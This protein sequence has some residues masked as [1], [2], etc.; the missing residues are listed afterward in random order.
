MIKFAVSRRLA[1][2]L[3]VLGWLS[4]GAPRVAAETLSAADYYQRLTR[5]QL[6]LGEGGDRNQLAAELAAIEAV[7]AADGSAV[8]LATPHLVERLRDPETDLATLNALLAA[9]AAAAALAGAP[10]AADDP[11]AVLAGVLARPEFDYGPQPQNWRERLWRQL[12]AWWFELLDLLFGDL[13]PA[14]GSGVLALILL[15]LLLGVLLYLWARGVRR[16]FVP[17]GRAAAA[18]PFDELLTIAEA[19]ALAR[20][21][22]EQQHYREALRYLYLA[23][24]LTLDEHDLLRFDR[25]KTNREYLR[26]L[27]P[28]ARRAALEPVLQR[29]VDGFDR[30]WYGFEPIDADGYA[31]Y[32]QTIDQ[33]LTLPAEGR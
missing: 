5:I 8:P 28:G 32:S 2:L 15:L 11:S 10:P 23:A 6:Q 22:A 24:L 26:A 4:I 1:V 3:V 25:S 16:S 18:N 12:Q 30:V 33:L 9:E 29:A 17:P 7:T 13:E 14:R 27:R 21:H 20:S 19:Q 31:Q